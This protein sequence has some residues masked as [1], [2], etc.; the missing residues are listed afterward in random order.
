MVYVSDSLILWR[1]RPGSKRSRALIYLVLSEGLPCDGVEPFNSEPFELELDTTCPGWR[2]GEGEASLTLDITATA[3]QATIS[4]G[5]RGERAR[6]LLAALAARHG[7]EIFDP[8]KDRI[9]PKDERAAAT[10][11]ANLT[12]VA[13]REEIEVWRRAA[14]GG[15]PNAMNELGNAYSFGEGV[16]EDAAIAAQWYA[17]A[18]ALGHTGAMIN[19]A[20]C[21]RRGEGVAQD[22]ASTAR[23]FERAGDAGNIE[24][25]VRLAELYRTGDGLPRD[26][27]RA[28]TFL[29]RAARE[30]Q[31]VSVFMLAEIYERGEAGARDLERAKELYRIALAN[32][33][34]EARVRLRRLGVEL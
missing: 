12:A 5:P 28:V 13:K 15:D 11:I 10:Y 3:L 2:N 9:S 4:T 16:R 7:L 29:E 21:Y 19:L 24:A 20:E 6:E 22:A 34:P 31:Q 17:R 23:W 33:H 14:E 8:R 26:P 25:L 1:S 18:A 27:A 32:R 30:E